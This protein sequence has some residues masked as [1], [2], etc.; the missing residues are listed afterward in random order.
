[1]T[2]LDVVIGG[3]GVR[4]KGVTVSRSLDAFLGTASVTLAAE[5]GVTLRPGARVWI[6]TDD[7]RQLDLLGGH[8]EAVSGSGGAQGGEITLDC[9]DLSSDMLDGRPLDVQW[10]WITPTTLGAVAAAVT[11]PYGLGVIDRVGAAELALPRLVAQPAETAYALLERAARFHGV[12]VSTTSFGDVRLSRPGDR[13]DRALVTLRTG[14]GANITRWSFRNDHSQRFAA[15]K[16]VGVANLVG[17][18][19]GTPARPGG[20]ARD[21]AIRETKTSVQ[22]AVGDLA[23]DE[24]DAQAAWQVAVARARSLTLTVDVPSLVTEEGGTLWRPGLL[25]PVEIPE[26]GLSGEMLVASVE[27]AWDLGGERASLGLVMPDAYAVD[28]TEAARLRRG[29]PEVLVDA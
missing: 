28:P 1:M 15:L 4:A 12:L 16:L 25:V 10:S 7:A 3:R 24:L 19:T 23:F 11:A 5:P 6:S 26:I 8:V 22:V 18:A 20:V 9:R 14:R 29:S 17:L 2:R 27:L 13:A 21:E